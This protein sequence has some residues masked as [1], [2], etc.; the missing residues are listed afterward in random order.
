MEIQKIE[1]KIRDLTKGYYDL[2]E[3]GCFAHNGDLNIRPPFQREFVYKDKQREAVIS[4]IIKGF[5][6]NVMY[7]SKQEKGF[8]VIDGQQR[9][10]SICQY[11]NGDFSFN[12]RYFQNLTKEEQDQILDYEIDVYVCEGSDKE[13]LD[14]FQ[15]INIAGEYLFKQ[16]LR[17]A[18]YTGPWLASAKE[19][20]SKTNCPAYQ[21]A[22]QYMNGSPIRQD[23][24]ETVLGWITKDSI[25][26]Y[27]SKKQNSP[28]ADDLWSF[29]KG[30][31][32]WI[33][34]L[35]PEFRKEMK[36]LPWGLLFIKYSAFQF[37]INELSEDIESLMLD[38]EVT[39]KK[40]IYEYLLSEKTL[41]NKLNIRTFTSK[42]K[43]KA[44]IKQNGVCPK[45]SYTFPENEMQGD[46]VIPWSQGGK[47]N[48]ENL[49][50]LCQGCN[51]RKGDR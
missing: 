11:V 12:D 37:D 40:G 44:F 51:G 27:M 39:N 32:N 26:S 46:H 5:P 50:M 17:N 14:W 48:D 36:G 25:E 34:N 1:I 16:E 43:S 2:T 10:I 8:E 9:T 7:W 30:V 4:T 18:I 6:L 23:Y 29:F 42:Q 35:F 31:I 20:F 41:Q 24:L 21:I 3:K 13:K 49:Q 19:H 47:T 15:I 22:S 45:C 33:N 28:N 38:D